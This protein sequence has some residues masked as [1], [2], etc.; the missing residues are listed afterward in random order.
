MFRYSTGGSND[1]S[2][3]PDSILNPV[4]STAVK[5]PINGSRFTNNGPNKKYSETIRD[6]ITMFA[7]QIRRRH[8]DT[9]MILET[10]C[11]NGFENFLKDTTTFL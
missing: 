10:N 9:I 4:T 11:R 5:A 1:D 2:R 3:L 8:I 6:R 7:D